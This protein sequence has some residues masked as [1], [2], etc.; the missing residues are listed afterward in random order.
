[1]GSLIVI[2][3]ASLLHLTLNIVV[4][5]LTIWLGRDVSSVWLLVSKAMLIFAFSPIELFPKGLQPILM[6]LPTTHVIYTPASLFVHFNMENF[7]FAV[8]CEMI[9]LLVVAGILTILYMKGVKKQ[10]VNGI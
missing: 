7:L 5:L 8:F 3:L 1:M 2:L 6:A 9:A 10:N 4:G